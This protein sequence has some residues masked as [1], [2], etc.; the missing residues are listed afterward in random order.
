MQLSTRTDNYNMIKYVTTNKNYILR[1]K[2][3][4]FQ[5]PNLTFYAKQHSGISES[6]SMMKRDGPVSGATVK[7]DSLG[8]WY[9]PFPKKFLIAWNQTSPL[10]P[11]PASPVSGL[12][13]FRPTGQSTQT[14]PLNELKCCS[15]HAYILGSQRQKINMIAANTPKFKWTNH[16]FNQLIY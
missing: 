15:G 3:L 10:S 1:Q 6:G 5:N 2:G 7:S 11:S 14:S 4:K 8:E 12:V 16:L 13:H 9:M